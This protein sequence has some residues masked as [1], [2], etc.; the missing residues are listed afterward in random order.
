MNFIIFSKHTYIL[1][2]TKYIFEN[3]ER[4]NINFTFS[5]MNEKYGNI[6]YALIYM[7]MANILDINF[8]QLPEKQQN[9]MWHQKHSVTQ[10]RR[11]TLRETISA[12]K[13]DQA[14]STIQF[15]LHFNTRR[16]QRFLLLTVQSMQKQRLK[17]QLCIPI[18]FAL[19]VQQYILIL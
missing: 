7:L 13:I 12:Y 8:H 16:K 9:R 3:S 19:S 15:L 11:K 10:I 5:H 2:I 4:K 17:S 14:L 18:T 6:T 1:L